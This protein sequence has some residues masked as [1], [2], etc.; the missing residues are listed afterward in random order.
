[1]LPVLICKQVERLMNHISIIVMVIRKG[2]RFHPPVVAEGLL[3]PSLQPRGDKY[4]VF[5]SNLPFDRN[6][7]NIRR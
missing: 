3:A 7:Y 6:N 4:I 1:M 2:L 5:T